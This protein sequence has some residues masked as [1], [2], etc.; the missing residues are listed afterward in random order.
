[1]SSWTSLRGRRKLKLT[2]LVRAS[3][4]RSELHTLAGTSHL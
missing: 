4:A 1:M 2:S 3:S